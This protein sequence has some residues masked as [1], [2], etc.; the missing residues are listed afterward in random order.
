MGS[1]PEHDK[2]DVTMKLHEFS[3]LLGDALDGGTKYVL[4]ERQ[5]SEC[6]RCEGAGKW[7][8]RGDECGRCDGTGL[9][10]TGTELTLA[11]GGMNRVLAALLGVD[12]DKLMNEK[13]QMLAEIRSA[14]K[15]ESDDQDQ[16]HHGDR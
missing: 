4:A 13:D 7:G 5:P 16:N 8:F 1:Y 12:Y 15:D 10:P 6:A 11:R 3:Q 14:R 9:D 2:L